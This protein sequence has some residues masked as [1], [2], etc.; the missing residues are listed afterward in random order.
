MKS[1]IRVEVCNVC[2]A[3]ASCAPDA[4]DLPVCRVCDPDNWELA[5]EL[6]KQMWFNGAFSEALESNG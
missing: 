5:S 1:R 2:G 4:R 6:D 3:E